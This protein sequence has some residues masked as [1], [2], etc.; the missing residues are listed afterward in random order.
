MLLVNPLHRRASG[1][2]TGA[3]PYFPSS[4]LFRNP[5]YLRIEDLPGSS[6]RT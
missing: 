4:R 5:I 1:D 6:R 2:T 3:E